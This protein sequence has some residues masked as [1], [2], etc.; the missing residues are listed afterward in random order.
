MQ[1]GVLVAKK[2]RGGFGLA[3]FATG[4]VYGLQVRLLGLAVLP[5][6]CLICHILHGCDGTL[7]AWVRCWLRSATMLAA[8]ALQPRSLPAA[9]PRHT[10]APHPAPPNFYSLLPCLS[11][12]AAVAS[13]ASLPCLFVLTASISPSLPAHSPMPC[14]SSC[15]LPWPH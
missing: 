9:P 7:T 11:R 12:S 5:L 6:G 2:E 4:I 13:H 3:T 15:L 10:V 14:L 1:G 8:A